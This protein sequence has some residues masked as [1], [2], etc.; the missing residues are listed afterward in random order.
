MIRPTARRFGDPGGQYGWNDLRR[1]GKGEKTPLALYGILPEMHSYRG[2][3]LEGEYWGVVVK[4][5][6][7]AVEKIYGRDPIEPGYAMI[8]NL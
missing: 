1:P 3:D 6:R 4:L 2:E 5:P 8:G 7:R